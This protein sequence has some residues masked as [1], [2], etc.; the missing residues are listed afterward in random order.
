MIFLCGQKNAE[1]DY[2]FPIAVARTV[3]IAQEQYKICPS[4][5]CHTVAIFIEFYGLKTN[6]E[7]IGGQN[8]NFT[9]IF[10]PRRLMH[11]SGKIWTLR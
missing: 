1:H 9:P 10:H 3:H 7:F 11:F 2:Y 8:P 5:T 4:V 6:I